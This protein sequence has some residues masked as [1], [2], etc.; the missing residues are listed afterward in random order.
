MPATLTTSGLQIQTLAEI[1]AELKTEFTAA[2]AFPG[3]DVESATSPL[4]VLIALQARREAVY[5]ALLASVLDSLYRD[6]AQGRI[7]DRLATITGDLPR[8]G[9]SQS[10][11]QGRLSGTP[12]TDCANKLVRY[13]PN[14]TLWR[15]PG[16]GATIGGGGTVDVELRAEDDGAVEA[17][18]NS[19]DWEV[20]TATTGW[21]S[22]ESLG[23][24]QVGELEEDDPTFRARLVASE[25]VARGTEQAI[26]AAL[27]RVPGVTSVA[28]DNNRTL[29]TNANGVPGKTV[30]ALVV[31]GSDQDVADALFEVVCGDT[32]TFGNTTVEVE[33]PDGRPLDVLFSRV[34]ELQAYALVTLTSTG[35]EEDLPSDY[36]DQVRAA[37]AARAAQLA[38][39]QDLHQAWFVG[40]I[41]DALPTNSVVDV[42]VL[43]DLDPGGAGATTLAVTNRQLAT[44]GNAATPG[45][46]VGSISQ[47]FAVTL[48]WQLVLA[49][50]GGGDQT[51]TF[52]GGAAMT[53]QDVADEIAGALTGATASAVV[54]KLK[55]ASDTTGA[56]SSIEVRPGSTAGLLAALGLS[57]GTYTGANNDIVSVTVV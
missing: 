31:G 38:P 54:S 37:V 14:G 26:V 16:T 11:I 17:E 25:S 2:G 51:I 36:E 12:G 23:S 49:V 22:V 56:S 3:H 53:A 35:A 8:Q 7:L 24:L 5:Q 20:V 41:V 9:P 28:L 39:G 42:D 21:D 46:V 18:E 43:F 40:A 6:G 55:I 10:T 47:P 57:V 15:T 13:A 34:E 52:T 44:I 45:Q 19:A 50:D 1:L 4:A 30:E 33:R 48:G 32:G 27:L 29:V